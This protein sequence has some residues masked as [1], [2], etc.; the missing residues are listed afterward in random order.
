MIVNKWV[1]QFPWFFL[2]SSILL[3]NSISVVV[4]KCPT[5]SN[6]AK[7]MFKEKSFLALLIV[8]YI[9]LKV[10]IRKKTI[11]MQS[12]QNKASFLKL[13]LTSK[14]VHVP[15]ALLIISEYNIHVSYTWVMNEYFI[16]TSPSVY[17]CGP[18]SKS[19]KLFEW[20]IDFWIVSDKK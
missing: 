19:R 2:H 4:S 6:Y 3:F 20:W 8:L 10:R 5:D 14:N 12:K 9:L 11:W 7:M 18:K 13:S 17:A 15:N 1:C 16:R